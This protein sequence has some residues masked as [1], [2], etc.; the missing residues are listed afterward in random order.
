M[1]SADD[2]WCVQS[3]RLDL[4]HHLF[5]LVF[6]LGK[7]AD[8]VRNPV[9]YG[10]RSIPDIL[11]CSS[12][13]HHLRQTSYLNTSITLYRYLLR[14]HRLDFVFCYR[15]SQHHSHPLLVPYTASVSGMVSHQLLPHGWNGPQ[16]C[17]Q[18]WHK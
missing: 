10:L 5:Q 4:L 6:R 13:P 1:G 11:G 9:V 14:L 17:C 18:V 2:L 12:W 3:G 16:V 8:K 15:S 7:E